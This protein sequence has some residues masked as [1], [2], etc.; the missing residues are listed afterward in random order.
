MICYVDMEHRV[1]LSSAELR[2]NHQAWCED[3]KRKLEEI[4]GAVCLVLHYTRLTRQWLD[5]AGI[6]ALVFSGNV[7]DW[8]EYDETDLQRLARII[9]GTHLPILGLCGGL[10]LI[11]IAYGTPIGPMRRLAIGERDVQPGMGERYF[12]EW[13]FVGV[14]VRQ[15]NP[16]FAGLG[17]EPVFLAAH[18]VELKKVPPG[19]ELLAST[20]ACR[21]QAI[22][23]TGRP[24]YGT[25]F[26]P[27]GYTEGPN[28]RRSWL[29]N[30][31]YPGGC[32]ESRPD[33]RRV[34]VNFFRAAGIA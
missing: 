23:Q 27:E 7:A 1:A 31:V 8:D 6:K 32:P 24:V 2:A 34:L 10:Q 9:R 15:P 14:R 19:F 18:Y 26:H 21:I 25:Q 17:E 30:L 4:S 29:V 12:K 5:E 33:G 28:D 11:A 20:D 13:G 16:L 3:V 22:R